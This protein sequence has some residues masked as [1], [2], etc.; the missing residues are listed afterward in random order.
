MA[1]AGAAAGSKKIQAQ[2]IVDGDKFAKTW[3]NLPGAVS[4]SETSTSLAEA[5]GQNDVPKQASFDLVW[6][7]CT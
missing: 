1:G 2:I 3:R 6:T 5:L 4:S 7:R